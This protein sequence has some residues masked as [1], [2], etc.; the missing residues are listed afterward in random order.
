[1]VRRSICSISILLLCIIITS[2]GKV[3]RTDSSNKEEAVE[4][5][6]EKKQISL[7]PA[8]TTLDTEGHENLGIESFFYS[9]EISEATKERISGK[10]YGEK[11]DVPY[12]ELRYIRV[13]HLGFDGLSHVG[14]LIV[15]KS[16][17]EDIVA[18]FKELY[19][20]NYPIERMVLKR[21][22]TQMTL[23]PW[24]PIIRRPLI[25]AISMERKSDPYT[26][27]E[28]RLILIHYITLLSEKLMGK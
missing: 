11:C 19:E 21:N 10:S 23:P 14:E 15:N 9:E 20:L 4:A 24:R 17:A 26:V 3:D 2:C 7:Y 28:W 25:F 12:S 18:I 1:M 16:I 5:L 27:M 22:T 8:G 6:E 13:L